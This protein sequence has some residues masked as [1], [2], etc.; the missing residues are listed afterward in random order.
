MK[1]KG[2]LTIV[3]TKWRVG[4]TCAE[5]LCNYRVDLQSKIQVPALKP[6]PGTC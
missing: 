2:M 5:N 6:R 1:V 4:S 3:F